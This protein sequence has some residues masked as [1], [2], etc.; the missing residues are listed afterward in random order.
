MCNERAYD[1][2]A[3][4]SKENEEGGTHVSF[5]MTPKRQLIISHLELSAALTGAQQA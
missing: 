3:Y 2:V 5:V 1:S 4:L